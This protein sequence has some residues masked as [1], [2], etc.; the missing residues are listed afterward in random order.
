[1]PGR[2]RCCPAGA[3]IS[4]IAEFVHAGGEAQAHFWHGA[5]QALLIQEAF[6]QPVAGSL[7]GNP[8]VVEAHR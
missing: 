6:L 2:Q 5:V 7:A 1:M 4:G 3:W 8:P